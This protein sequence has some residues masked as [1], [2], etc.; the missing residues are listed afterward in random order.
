MIIKQAVAGVLRNIIKPTMKTKFKTW[1]D[2]S[3][4][5][6]WEEIPT[7]FTWPEPIPE[8]DTNELGMLLLLLKTYSE[9]TRSAFQ[10][11]NQTLK[12]PNYGVN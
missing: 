3:G 12:T 9:G 8:A 2:V 11:H 4:A 6:S 5:G 7:N 10:N 1:S